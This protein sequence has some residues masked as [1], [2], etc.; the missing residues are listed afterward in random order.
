MVAIFRWPVYMAA[1]GLVFVMPACEG[2]RTARGQIVDSVTKQPLDSVKCEILTA[3]SQVV[4]TDSIGKF[5]ARNNFGG[6]IPNCKDITIRLSKAKY[7]EQIITNPVDTI[8]YLVKT[9]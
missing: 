4:Y 8:F 5:S 7:N 6:C 9:P 1:V 2:Y 3:A